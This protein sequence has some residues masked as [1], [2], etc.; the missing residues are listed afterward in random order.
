MR[1]WL[2]RRGKRK[3]RLD[4]YAPYA[5]SLVCLLSCEVWP[6]LLNNRR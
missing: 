2:G 3:T 1:S 6:E 5:G 4:E